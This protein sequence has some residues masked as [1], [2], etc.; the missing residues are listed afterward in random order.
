MG[1]VLESGMLYSLHGELDTV[2]GERVF[3]AT[4]ALPVVDAEGGV[5]AA[6][7]RPLGVSIK[8]LASEAL[9]PI[10][11]LVRTVGR[12]QSVHPSDGYFVVSGGGG[13]SLKVQPPG[14]CRRSLR[15]LT[16][17]IRTGG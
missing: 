10:G 1:R 2:E 3:L 16:P 13:L 17:Q 4:S 14:S 7:C 12:V 15:R 11:L 5:S 8:N 6:L 9:S